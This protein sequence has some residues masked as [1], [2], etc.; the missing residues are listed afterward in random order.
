MKMPKTERLRNSPSSKKQHFTRSLKNKLLHME[1]ET[2]QNSK[3][4]KM[5]ELCFWYKEKQDRSCILSTNGEEMFVLIFLLNDFLF[6]LKKKN[7]V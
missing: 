2:E 4:S 5:F 6:F 7:Q 1:N 3:D